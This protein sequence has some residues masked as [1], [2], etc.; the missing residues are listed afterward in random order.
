VRF[1]PYLFFSPAA[2]IG[3][4]AATYRLKI[5][6]EERF[7]KR[8]HTNVCFRALFQMPPVEAALPTDYNEA[9]PTNME[10]P[11]HAQ[12]DGDWTEAQ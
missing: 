4:V 7:M 12:L 5:A 11:H 6:V 10:Q 2:V 3:S 1:A 8:K 9:P